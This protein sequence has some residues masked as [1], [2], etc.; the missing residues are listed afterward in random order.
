MKFTKEN[1]REN[2]SKISL[3]AYLYLQ[4][5]SKVFAQNADCK[6]D[7]GKLCP[8]VPGI[9]T[10]GGLI[11]K[12]LNGALRIGMPVV[13]LAIIYCGFLFVVARGNSEK[14]TK[15][16]EALMYTLIGAAVLLGSWAIATMISDTVLAL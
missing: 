4:P 2:F 1:Y 16:K 6:P 10:V 12:L 11:E 15:A 5:F 7:G 13:A 9:T 3:L 14:I 8:P